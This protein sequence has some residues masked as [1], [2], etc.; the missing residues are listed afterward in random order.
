MGNGT[1]NVSLRSFLQGSSVIL[2]MRARE[3]KGMENEELTR[4]DLRIG[5]C[6]VEI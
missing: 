3:C 5:A 2:S 1:D 6:G 4:H